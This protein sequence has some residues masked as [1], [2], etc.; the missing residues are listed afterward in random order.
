MGTA[1]VSGSAEVRK[2]GEVRETVE[3]AS[4]KTGGGS[5]Y[6]NGQTGSVHEKSEWRLLL[7]K[8]IETK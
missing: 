2:A 1:E 3:W 7:H 4:V 5:A 8:D 6:M